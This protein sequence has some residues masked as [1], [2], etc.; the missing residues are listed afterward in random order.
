MEHTFQLLSELE[1]ALHLQLG[2]HAFFCII[3]YR[4]TRKKTLCKMPLVILLK[5]VF[6]GDESEDGD[7][8]VKYDVDF[9]VRFLSGT[10]EPTREICESMLHNRIASVC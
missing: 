6:I 10:E 5:D 4:A 7:S 8:F 1:S 3:R 2:Q 9:V